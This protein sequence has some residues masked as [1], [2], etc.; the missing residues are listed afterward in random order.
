MLYT[1]S[2]SL[3]SR[4]LQI[5]F[6]LGC[7][8]RPSQ[9]PPPPSLE[10]SDPLNSSLGRCSY[11][12][13]HCSLQR[14]KFHDCW[15]GCVGGGGVQGGG[16]NGCR[17]EGESS[18]VPRTSFTTHLQTLTFRS[19]SLFV[20]SSEHV[21]FYTR[22]M[23]FDSNFVCVKARRRREVREEELEELRDGLLMESGIRGGGETLGT[24]SLDCVLYVEG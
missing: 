14:K 2:F 11:S 17:P 24:R 13:H 20:Y 3:H 12:V 1:S 6:F 18:L 5:Y 15:S 4:F 10:S 9:L 22:S 23:L 8:L 16:G 7:L 21:L 19:C